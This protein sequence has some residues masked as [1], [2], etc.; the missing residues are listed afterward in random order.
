MSPP[1]GARTRTRTPDAELMASAATEQPLPVDLV[2]DEDGPAP[3]FPPGEVRFTRPQAMRTRAFWLVTVAMV[4]NA[5]I[6]TA[7][8]FLLR[9]LADDVGLAPGADNRLLAVF[10]V[11]SALFGPVAG[12]AADRVRPGVIISSASFLLGLSCAIFALAG[13]E[14]IPGSAATAL[15]WASMVALS[16]SQSLVFICGSTFVARFFGRPHHGAIRAALTFFM[17]VGTSAG[18][19]LTAALAQPLGYSGALWVFAAACVPIAL[20]GLAL[21]RPQAPG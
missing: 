13:L 17:V 7:F 4:A 10:A 21:R 19:F 16:A 9:K 20:A 18:P 8:V 6:G 12:I 2:D 15:A 14:A 3:G 1:R 5:I 11:A